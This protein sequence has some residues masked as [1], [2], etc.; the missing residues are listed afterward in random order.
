MH[1]ARL[2][3]VTAICLGFAFFL[4]REIWL[5]LKTGKVAYSRGNRLYCHRSKNPWG[6]WFLVILFSGFIAMSLVLWLRVLIT[7]SPN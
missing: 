1:A 5:G 7:Q 6:F 4:G 2:L 3:L